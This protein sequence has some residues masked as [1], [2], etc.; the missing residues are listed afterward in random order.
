MN[1][2]TTYLPIQKV[3]RVGNSVGCGLGALFIATPF[4]K[5]NWVEI[6]ES[7]F[8]LV[9]RSA[10]IERIRRILFVIKIE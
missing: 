9:R 5:A 3:R 10:K 8:Y 2:L 4:I 6:K 1:L 7:I